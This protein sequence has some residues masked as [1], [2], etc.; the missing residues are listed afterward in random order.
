M[1]ETSWTEVAAAAADTVFAWPSAEVAA[2]E[3]TSTCVDKA[4]TASESVAR[5]VETVFA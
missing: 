2:A 5:F 1:T 4:D 3:A